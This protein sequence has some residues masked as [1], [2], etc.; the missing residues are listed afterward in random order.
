MSNNPLSQY[1]RQ[2]AVH[3]RLPSGGKFYPKG[4]LE[5]TANGEY[6]VL[7]MTTM[8]E[9]TYRTPDALF[10]GS[11]VTSVIQSCV[12]NI[13]DAWVMPSVDIDAV[14]V[15]IRIATYGHEMEITT[16]CPSCNTESDYGVD[17]RRVLDRIQP[18]DYNEPLI[19][20]QLQVYLRPMTYRQINT[21]SMMQFEDQKTLQMLQDSSTSDQEKLTRLNEVLKKITTMTTQALAQSIMMVKTPDGAS[22]TD[23]AHITEWLA[24][25]DRTTF[26][27]IRDHI[28]RT[29]QM[30]EIQPLSMTCGNC[31]H[32]YS[33][34][35][36]LDMSN[37]FG[38]AS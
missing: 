23:A 24:N 1:F 20:D 11:A 15:G 10:N 3:I 7:P 37:F 29:K 36:T 25:C 13:R 19:L 5:V 14:L 27:T 18:A 9:I 33:Q 34:A 28:V 22:V 17:L 38:A 8:D 21:N 6:G 4:T 32:Q 2:P 30:A 26:A 31:S 16:Q 35:Y 12:P